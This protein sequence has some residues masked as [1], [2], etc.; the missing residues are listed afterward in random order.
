[1]V[2]QPRFNNQWLRPCFQT[3]VEVLKVFKIL[4]G[5]TYKQNKNQTNKQK[6]THKDFAG[7]NVA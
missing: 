3:C 4:K 7:P 1:M 2:N 6:K 5:K